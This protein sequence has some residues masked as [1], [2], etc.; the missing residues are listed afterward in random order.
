MTEKKSEVHCAVCGK[1]FNIK[2]EPE[3][4]A[5]IQKLRPNMKHVCGHGCT[6]EDMILKIAK[7]SE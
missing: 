5:L 6:A 4:W 3:A 1:P 7:E 2:M